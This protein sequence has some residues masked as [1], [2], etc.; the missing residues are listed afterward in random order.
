MK[1]ASDA[2]RNLSYRI[3]SSKIKELI[4]Y[5]QWLG[6]FHCGDRWVD[7]GVDW[8]SF[9]IFAYNYLGPLKT[10]KNYH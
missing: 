8:N 4:H 3:I 10:P 6:P 7:A 1:E 2:I 5:H 9:G